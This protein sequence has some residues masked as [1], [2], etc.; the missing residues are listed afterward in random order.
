[1]KSTNAII[2]RRVYYSFALSFF[3][4]RL[5]W[6]GMVLGAGIALTARLV[7]V[8]SIINNFLS[9]P[10]GSV[11]LYIGNAFLNAMT[12]GE[13]LTVLTVLLCTGLGVSVLLQLLAKMTPR[14]PV[15]M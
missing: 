12:H 9:I 11:P 4:E 1:M 10:V 6:Q 5:F 3:A 2:M 13:L 14:T 15:W 7:H 8:A